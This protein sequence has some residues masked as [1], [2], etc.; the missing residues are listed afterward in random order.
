MSAIRILPYDALYQQGVIDTILPIQ[1]IEFK[2]PI[3]LADQPDLLDIPG[4]YQAG[5]GNFWVAVSD[6]TCSTGQV[7][8]TIAL[9]DFGEGR[10]ALRKM[11]V[12]GPWRGPQH[13]IAALLLDALLRH[14]R[15]RGMREIYLGTTSVM[16]AAHRFYEK[17]GFAPV[18]A[19]A[20]P[21][22]FPRM[23]VDTRFYRIAL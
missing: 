11:F 10:G 2:V 22:D 12:Q 5:Q 23:T 9:R 18:E 8:G 6:K 17:N 15:E 7:I 21:P 14:A 20:L 3:T 4:F 16:P 19:G 1:Q 13:G